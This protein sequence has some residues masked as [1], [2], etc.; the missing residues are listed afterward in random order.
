MD[1]IDFSKKKS[2]IL[3]QILHSSDL[4][5]IDNSKALYDYYKYI[6]FFRH[7]L[8]HYLVLESL[9]QAWTEEK[10]LQDL[11]DIKMPKEYALKTPDIYL[12]KDKVVLLIDVSISFDIHKSKIQKEEKYGNIAKWLTENNNI[13]TI[14]IHINVQSSYANLL[15]E[16]EK[17]KNY[18]Q[19]EFDNNTFF[20]AM[21]IIEDKKKMGE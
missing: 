9:G 7:N 19:S 1:Y 8:L 16:I 14:F 6:H 2:T 20:R 4:I 5:P 18:Q 12:R 13:N 10:Q 21:S 3:Y 15:Q 17:I 11:V